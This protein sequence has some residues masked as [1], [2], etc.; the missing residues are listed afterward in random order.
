MEMVYQK[1]QAEQLGTDGDGQSPCQ[2]AGKEMLQAF[3]CWLPQCHQPQGCGK[4]QLEPRIQDP[5]RMPGQQQDPG[6]TQ[7][8]RAFCP[9]SAGLSP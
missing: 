9:A 3:C 4:R 7:E 5:P 8:S 2:E 1:R 6:Q